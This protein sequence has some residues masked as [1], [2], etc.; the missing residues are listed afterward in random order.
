M[1]IA[2]FSKGY[3]PP[4]LE[5]TLLMAH[6]NAQIKECIDECLDCHRTCLETIHY[7]LSKGGKHAEAKHIELLQSCASICETSAQFMISGLDLHTQTCAVCSEVCTRC[8]ESCEEMGDD[9]AMK[10]CADACRACAESCEQMS[11]EKAA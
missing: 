1:N 7:C 6:D 8:A 2:A 11:R 3:N 5:R 4:K 9:L 10:R